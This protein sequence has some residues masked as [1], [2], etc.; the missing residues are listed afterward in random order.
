[1]RPTLLLL[2]PGSGLGAR[3]LLAHPLPFDARV[4]LDRAAPDSEHPGEGAGRHLA[5]F[6]DEEATA[7]LCGRLSPW[8]GVLI[9]PSLDLREG[10]SPD[11][12]LHQLATACFCAFKATFRPLMHQRRGS[13]WMARPQV[14]VAPSLACQELDSCI[15]AVN[16][17]LASLCG[18]VAAELAKKGVVANFLDLPRGP[19]RIEDV[20]RFLGWAVEQP[21]LYLTGERIAIGPGGHLP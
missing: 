4:V 9:W 5:D 14:K 3:A 2:F 8:D 17:G 15:A 10:A 13:L 21:S 6:L 20:L 19:A 7:E 11:E 12:A 1:M 18:V 16:E